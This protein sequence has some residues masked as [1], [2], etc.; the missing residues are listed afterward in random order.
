MFGLMMLS[1]KPGLQRDQIYRLCRECAAADPLGAGGKSPDR[2]RGQTGGGVTGAQGYGRGGF[3]PSLSLREAERGGAPV[4][5]RGDMRQISRRR[6]QPAEVGQNCG[7]RRY[8]RWVKRK[9][10]SD[11]SKASSKRAEALAAL[12][13]KREAIEADPLMA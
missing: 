3:R 13:A 2:D 1:S 9:I 11:P 7:Y 12:G 10:I 6:D 4:H 5:A 8:Q